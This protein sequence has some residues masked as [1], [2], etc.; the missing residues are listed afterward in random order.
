[1]SCPTLAHRAPLSMGFAR[2]EYWNGMPFSP[3]GD[4]PD[5]GIKP[6]SSALQ[7]DSLLTQPPVLLTVRKLHCASKLRMQLF[8]I[9]D[10]QSPLSP[11]NQSFWGSTCGLLLCGSSMCGLKALSRVAHPC[12]FCVTRIT[13]LS[14]YLQGIGPMAP[15]GYHILRCSD[16]L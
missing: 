13:V 15:H 5:P 2:Q 12:Y 9:T 7:A 3:L 16:P 11:Q 6:R 4:L 8:S 1:M 10:F 14:L